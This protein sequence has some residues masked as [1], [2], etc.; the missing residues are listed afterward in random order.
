M[1]KGVKWILA[2]PFGK[3]DLDLESLVRVVVV[4][5]NAVVCHLVR[6]GVR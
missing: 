6:N 4:V 2:Q 3:V 1:C 5:V